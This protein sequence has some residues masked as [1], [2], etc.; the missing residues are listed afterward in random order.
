MA[1]AVGSGPGPRWGGWVRLPPVPGA[2]PARTNELLLL[3]APEPRAR[4][5]PRHHLLY[6]PGDV[7]NYGEVMARHPENVQWDRWSLES[8]AA[9]LSA[10][11]P[12]SHVW[13]VKCSRMHLHKF[14]CY[15]NFVRSNTFGAPDHSPDFGALRHL[16]AL[17]T[18]A[19]ALAR[20]ALRAGDAG[21]EE[22]EEEEERPESASFTLIGF[23]KGCVV[24]NQF[25]F[26]LKGARADRDLAAFLRTVRAMYW[27]DGGH[28]GGSDTW[29]T[30][31]EALWE[32]SRTGISVHAHVTPYQVRDPMRS[33]IGREHGLF[34]QILADLGVGVKGQVHF[35]KEAPSIDNHFRVHE[36]F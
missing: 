9:L 17:L 15:D 19:F 6:F 32:L 20:D 12:G 31:P 27:L 34:V 22:E 23:S 5:R 33:W 16:R 35:A 25:L 11:F 10:R 18:N 28:S 4:P 1:S 14:S 8:V 36:V 24:L 13:V 30:C 29:V 7:Q 21:E 3:P 26:E 2:P